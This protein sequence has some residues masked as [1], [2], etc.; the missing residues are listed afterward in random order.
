[1]LGKDYMLAIILVNCDG[2]RSSRRTGAAGGRKG[3]RGEHLFG[4]RDAAA[5]GRTEWKQLR[6]RRPGGRPRPQKTVARDALGAFLL[7]SRTRIRVCVSGLWK[8]R[9][10]CLP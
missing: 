6:A 1:M 7:T 3:G 5:S 4:R 2:E 8:V 10:D 9:Q